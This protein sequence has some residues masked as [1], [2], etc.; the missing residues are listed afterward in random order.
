MNLQTSIYQHENSTLWTRSMRCLAYV[1]FLLYAALYL[2]L[3]VLPMWIARQWSIGYGEA[4]WVTALFAPGMWIPGVFSSYLVDAFPR[5]SVG[6]WG[7]L[8]LVTSTVL[9]A[10]MPDLWMVGALRV[11]QG[12]AFSLATMAVGSTLA[13]DA[14]PS[15]RRSDANTAFVWIA[16]LG[17]MA[18]VS[19]GLFLYAYQG[20]ETVTLT[21]AVLG[22]VAFLCLPVVSVPF[23]APL[24]A[25]LCTLD[26]F[27]LPRAWVPMCNLLPLVVAAGAITS[28]LSEGY[29]YL[30]AVAGVL[31]G[32]AVSRWMLAALPKRAGIELGMAATIGGFMLLAFTVSRQGLCIASL[33]V[34][35]GISLSASHLYGLMINKAQHCERASANNSYQLLWELGMMAGVVIASSMSPMASDFLY[36]ICAA[37]CLVSLGIFEG[38]TLLYNKV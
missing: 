30:F 25:P 21:A 6:M 28:R 19:C 37:L 27:F 1:H 29:A 10:Y 32:W 18:G 24:H 5:K 17:M 34:S 35:M 2:L 4:G 13:I 36:V 26:R 33:L 38:V 23:R 8:L 7:I 9:M 3:P 22:L 31:L 14:A 15:N 11:L 12:A 20:I 16:R